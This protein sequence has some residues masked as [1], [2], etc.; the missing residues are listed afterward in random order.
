MVV[1][2]RHRTEI[3]ALIIAT[4]IMILLIIALPLLG[5]NNHSSPRFDILFLIITTVLFCYFFG[6]ELRTYIICE[7]GV[8]I[9]WF[10]IL[11]YLIK[12]TE[13][14]YIDINI[15]KLRGIEHKAIILSKIPIKIIQVPFSA[16]SYYSV[17]DYDWIQIRSSKV[18]AIYI[19]DLKPGQYEE[20]W[21]Y[22]PERLKT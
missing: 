21:S 5:F 14:N 19:E 16:N 8:C 6:Y 1:K 3:I 18:I 17:V 9:R 13:I 2:Q 11:N 10:G 12:W 7:D 4:V 20:F 22:V 15:V